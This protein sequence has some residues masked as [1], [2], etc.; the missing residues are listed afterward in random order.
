MSAALA[1]RMRL[2]LVVV[3]RVAVHNL[4]MEHGLRVA[5]P[6]G[7]ER[8]DPS[9]QPG[10]VPALLKRV[11]EAHQ[12]RVEQYCSFQRCV[13]GVAEHPRALRTL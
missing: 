12:R 7:S 3:T 8:G 11:L 2:P 13:R 4:L 6:T 10:D 9:A 1:R 5:V